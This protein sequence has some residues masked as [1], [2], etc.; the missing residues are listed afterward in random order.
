MLVQ[1]YKNQGKKDPE[2][3]AGQGHINLFELAGSYLDSDLSFLLCRWRSASYRYSVF[4]RAIN[5]FPRSTS[6]SRSL[7][8]EKK[9]SLMIISLRSEFYFYMLDTPK[10]D[11]VFLAIANRV[12]F[13]S[14]SSLISE[15]E[16]VSESKC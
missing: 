6:S 7:V 11:N 13:L 1:L 3:L 14:K 9:E 4:S 15:S 8:G 5:L 2:R 16:M 10:C 12:F